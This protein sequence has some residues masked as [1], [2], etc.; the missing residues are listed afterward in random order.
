MKRPAMAGSWQDQCSHI[1]PHWQVPSAS[2]ST[3]R[4]GWVWSGCPI[5]R[6]R[7]RRA[8]RKRW[9]RF[10]QAWGNVHAVGF[11][12]VEPISFLGKEPLQPGWCWSVKD[13][14]R[15]RT[16]KAGHLWEPLESCSTESLPPWHG[17]GMRS[18]FV[19]SSSADL[20]EI[21]I[22]ELTRLISAV[23]S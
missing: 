2:T 13:P 17:G 3:F 4:P 5:N 22:R 15:R 23:P 7:P 6:P 1:S 20:Q 19:T 14:A 12:P 8:V 21:A 9:S 18:T 11:T 16:D 10:E